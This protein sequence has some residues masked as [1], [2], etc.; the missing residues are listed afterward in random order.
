MHV[1]TRGPLDSCTLG[2]LYSCTLVRVYAWTLG[3]LHSWTLEHFD[4]FE[5]DA[6]IIGNSYKLDPCTLLPLDSCTLEREN[7]WTLGPLGPG[8]IATL[9]HECLFLLWSTAVR[10]NGYYGARCRVFVCRV[11]ALPP[12][13]D[14][15]TGELA[16]QITKKLI[17]C[18]GINNDKTPSVVILPQAG[19]SFC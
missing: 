18:T 5:L 1:R 10:S 16:C 8:T 3:P 2:P 11:R 9:Q 13:M 7:T 15:R 12:K 4:Q 19:R 14:S 17:N 6:L